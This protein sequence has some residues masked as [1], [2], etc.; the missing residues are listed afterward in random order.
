MAEAHASPPPSLSR[1]NNAGNPTA[2]S[3]ARSSRTSFRTGEPGSA[4]PATPGGSARGDNRRVGAPGGMK[5]DLLQVK[6][7][8][9]RQMDET[10]PPRLKRFVQTD[11]CTN[12]LASLLMYLV[13]HFLTQVAERREERE[14][15]QADK[16]GG[17]SAS[18]ASELVAAAL[19]PGTARRSSGEL[20]EERDLHLDSVSEAYARVIVGNKDM[21]Q[22]AQKDRAFWEELLRF[23]NLA[24]AEAFVDQR[25]SAEIERELGRIFRGSS[26]NL[27]ARQQEQAARAT[28]T[29]DNIPLK[30]LYERKTDEDVLRARRFILDVRKRPSLTEPLTALATQRTPL[31]RQ[32]MPTP[33]EVFSRTMAARAAGM[34]TGRAA[35]PAATA[36]ATGAPAAAMDAFALQSGPSSSTVTA[37]AHRPRDVAARGDTPVRSPRLVAAKTSASPSPR[38]PKPRS[39]ASTPTMLP[40]LLPTRRT[41]LPRHLS[42]TPRA[43]RAMARAETSA[44]NRREQPVL[45]TKVHP[46]LA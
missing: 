41:E 23:L 29:V 33:K 4:V 16:D 28:V 7:R 46:V 34:V 31:L 35:H 45:A 15:K 27:T 39:G 2:A 9:E 1:A 19:D 11:L 18:S 38:V 43:Q 10:M 37:S 42:S 8:V 22:D 44:R 6:T 36:A 25:H 17:M 5:L 26:F 21:S 13:S 20:A 24:M 30:E 3:S 32:L 14:R 12:L 40:V